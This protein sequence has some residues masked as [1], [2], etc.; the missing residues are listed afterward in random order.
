MAG[1]TGWTSEESV[2]WNDV[3]TEPPPP[4]EDGIY[5]AIVVKAEPKPLGKENKPGIAIQL[6]VEEQFGG[7]AIEPKR[8]LFDNVM[9]SAA[10]AFKVKQLAT[11]ANI[12]PPASF[13]FA[14]VEAFCNALVDSNALLV[15]T[16]R[17]TY[18]PPGG[19]PRTNAKVDRYLTE[20]QLSDAGAEADAA[21]ADGGSR[22]R[23]G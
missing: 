16:K 13:K 3:S 9:M 19:S 14:D 2:N 12:E 18:T 8:K 20:Q 6:Q 7:G 22:R 11:A 4:L 15:R 10:A 1:N 5:R 21:A 17:E 23:R